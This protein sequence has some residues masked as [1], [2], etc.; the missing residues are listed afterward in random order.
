MTWI[1]AKPA[2]QPAPGNATDLQSLLVP[3]AP[4]PPPGYGPLPG[5]PPAS[6]AAPA[7]AAPLPAEQGAGR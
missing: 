1:P 4:G 2:T 6:A 3:Q 5:P 7:P